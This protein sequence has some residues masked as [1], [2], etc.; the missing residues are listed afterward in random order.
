MSGTWDRESRELATARA[1]SSATREPVQPIT[2]NM[3]AVE[4]ALIND[5]GASTS[6]SRP[7]QSS[8]S[9]SQPYH[10]DSSLQSVGGGSE[11]AAEQHVEEVGALTSSSGS[12]QPS[13]SSAHA[14]YGS[15]H[16][17]YLRSLISEDTQKFV[18]IKDRADFFT[19]G[20]S[21][22]FNLR[23]IINQSFP[24]GNISDSDYQDILNSFN[25]ISAEVSKD[26][27]TNPYRKPWYGLIISELEKISDKF[28]K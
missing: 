21:E 22:K 12:S 2:M 17:N 19:L 27:P 7:F 11:G 26:D 16:F 1:S 5:T 24:G 4:P 20:N 13:T 8:T 3:S 25:V 6:S 10:Q 28:A 14:M 9:L 15:K 23:Q 18:E